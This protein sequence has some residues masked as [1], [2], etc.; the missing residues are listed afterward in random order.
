MVRAAKKKRRRV[1]L[2]IDEAQHLATS[3]SFAPLAQALRTAIEGIE[4]T[5]PSALRTNLTGSSRTD[6]AALL[7]HRSA[8]FYKSFDHQELPDLG[9]EYTDFV[10]EQLARLG[11]VRIARQELAAVFDA[12]YR[13]PYYLQ[14][15]LAN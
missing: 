14:E 5:D 12:L 8:A 11:G 9:I 3:A 1:L 6:L 10:A 15:S 7:E 2:L 4:A 13:S